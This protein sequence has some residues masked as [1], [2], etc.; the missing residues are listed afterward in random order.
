MNNELNEE[1]A[2]RINDLVLKTN[3][4]LMDENKDLE[5]KLS[6]STNTIKLD[7]NI[8]RTLEKENGILQEENKKLKNKNIYLENSL[9][10]NI[11]MTKLDNNII[12]DLEKTQTELNQVI[13]LKNE[14][15]NKLKKYNPCNRFSNTIIKALEEE[16]K[17][18]QKE[19]KD[20][21][22]DNETLIK[23]NEELRE[24]IDCITSNCAPQDIIDE[25]NEEINELKN[26]NTTMINEMKRL[27]QRCHNLIDER[28]DKERLKENLDIKDKI[29]ESHKKERLELIQTVHVLKHEIK[30]IEKERDR[31]LNYHIAST[32]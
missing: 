16:I 29:I 7:N 14:E 22:D 17:K 9:T 32:K 13:S 23:D 24:E 8:I 30:S 25:L 19:N 28:E 21:I 27:N 6:E 11:N 15:I 26:K 18:L 1:I 5:I 31:I 4:I 20:V 12:K 3:R 10:E 2:E